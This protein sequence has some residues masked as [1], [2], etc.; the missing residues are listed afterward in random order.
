MPQP[1]ESVVIAVDGDAFTISYPDGRV[2]RGRLDQVTGV[3]IETNDS[4]PWGSD[5][6]WHLEVDGRLVSYAQGATGEGELL[7]L[8]QRLPGF[9]NEAVIRAMGSTDN[10]VFLAFR[11]SP[12]G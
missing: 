8:L 4:G 9:D 7:P 6:W 5:V 10:A 3:A 1:E 11:K 2:E 12:S